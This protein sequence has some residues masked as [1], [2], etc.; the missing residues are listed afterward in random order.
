MGNPWRDRRVLNYAHQGGAREAPSSTLFA[1]RQ[2]VAAGADAI[3]L[4]VHATLDGQLVVCHDATVD[5]TTEGF[6]AIPELSLAQLLTL[7]NAYWWVLGHESLHD[8]PIEAYVLRGRHR[9]D[10]SFGIATLAE[11]LDEL[12]DVFINLDIKETAPNVAP[13]EHL[14]ADVLRAYGRTDDVIVASFHDEALDRFRRY[15]PGVHTSLAISD[16]LAFGEAVVAGTP[17]P[18]FLPSQVALQL[19]RTYGEQVVIYEALVA[20]AHRADLAVHAW[21]IDD[22]EEMR[23]LIGIGIDG[24]MTDYPS[25]LNRVLDETRSGWRNG[26]APGGCEGGRRPTIKRFG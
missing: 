10:P 13:Y 2:A 21:T 11:V 15:A 6:G 25:V 5:R 12:T 3:E 22:P 9:T 19:P 18:R 16:S 14:L 8:A 20:A 1:I 4:D 17:L 7:D 26:A 23:Q 24:I